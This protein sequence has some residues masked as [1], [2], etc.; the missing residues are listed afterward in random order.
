MPGSIACAQAHAK[1]KYQA[2]QGFTA[3][4]LACEQ[5]HYSCVDRFLLH[6]WQ[7]AQP[8]NN[9]PEQKEADGSCQG[10]Q[11]ISSDPIDIDTVNCS[12][13][14]ALILL[15]RSKKLDG[16]AAC[17]ANFLKH[18][19]NL[20]IRDQYGACAL[21]ALP[22]SSAKHCSARAALVLALR[23]CTKCGQQADGSTTHP[24][25]GRCLSARYCS[26][27]CQ[28]NDWAKHKKHCH[29]VVKSS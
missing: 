18:R 5:G 15:C 2:K 28:Q 3:F 13:A 26:K 29:P 7:S 1:S 23:Q 6:Y 4:M 12:G 16:K 27:M 10:N 25:C 9:H 17:M 21:S 22:R 11:T 24:K 14:T 19:P 8:H 20:H